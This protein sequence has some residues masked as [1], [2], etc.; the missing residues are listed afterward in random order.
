MLNRIKLKAHAAYPPTHPDHGR[1][2]SGLD[3]YRAYGR[4]VGPILARFGGRQVW[5]GQPQAMVIGP[6]DRERWDLAFLVQY[7]SAKAFMSMMRDPEYH[8]AVPHRTA[9]VA[10]SRLLRLNP[11]DPSQG[12]GG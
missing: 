4:A 8:L 10:D 2:L 3:A 1:R 11:R 5:A 7:P 9:A 12:L 6:R